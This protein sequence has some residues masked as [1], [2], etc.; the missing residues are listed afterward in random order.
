MRI[1]MID[2]RI[3]V[4]SRLGG[5]VMM[6]IE[7]GLDHWIQ[8]RLYYRIYN[9]IGEIGRMTVYMNEKGK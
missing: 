3:I 8:D 5:I 4:K 7:S 6:H 2:Q 1:G 9:I